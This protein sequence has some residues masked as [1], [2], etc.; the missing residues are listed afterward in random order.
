MFAL[1]R[2]A[3]HLGGRWLPAG[4]AQ[5]VWER[6]V[7]DDPELSPLLSPAGVARSA[8]Q[9][10]RR[11]HDYCIPF[12]ALDG[13]D[14]VET[15]AFARWCRQYVQLL[16]SRSWLDAVLAQ[17]KVQ[18]AAAGAGLE[19]VGFDRLTPLQELLLAR[20]AEAGLEVRRL[21][22][23]ATTAAVRRVHCLDAAAEIDA[24]ARWAAAALHERRDRRI[25]IVVPD[26][27][28]RREDVRRR[29][30]RVLVPA[31][32]VTDGPAPESQ[33][34][35]L[36]AARPLAEQPV[37]A[38]KK[39]PPGPAWMRACVATRLRGSGFP[40]C[41]GWP[42]NAAARH[43]ARH[44]CGPATLC[45]NGLR[46]ISQLIV[47]IIFLMRWLRWGGPARHWTATSTRPSSGCARSC[48]NSA[49]TTNS[50]GG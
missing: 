18:A 33:G 8:Y 40:A 6:L 28:R 41:S 44:S 9:S 7:R 17:T 4:A 10:W 23:L 11:L 26:L 39:V 43:W 31:A 32:G 15:A 19:I 1:D 12:G 42:M 14:S 38:Q 3:G 16:E 25:A 50:R 37:V 30:E 35:E 47:L 29:V 48:P 49:V 2:Q 46:K 20:W 22:E 21:D 36:A 34:F 27:G 24:A 5:L 13:D 45:R